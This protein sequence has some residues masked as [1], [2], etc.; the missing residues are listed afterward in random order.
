MRVEENTARTETFGRQ[1]EAKAFTINGSGF[2]FKTIMSGI[3]ADKE[4]SV[5]REIVANAVDAH[6]MYKEATG[7]SPTR[8][9]IVTLPSVFDSNFTVRD[10]G[11]GMPH[12]FVMDLYSRLFH[13]EKQN[14]N[15][16][17]GMFGLGSKSPF[18]L[19]D[20]FTVTVY[21]DGT[22]R[23]YP[24]ALGPDGIP[25]IR[26]MLPTISKEPS[27][28]KICVPIDNSRMAAFNAAYKRQLVAFF[29]ADI[30]LG[31]HKRSGLS[32]TLAHI[33]LS[34]HIRRIS[35]GLY[36]VPVN[37]IG[38]L[39]V[40][41]GTAVY[42]LTSDIAHRIQ[43]AL[44]P[45]ARRA[46]DFYRTQQSQYGLILDVPIGTCEVVPSRESL[47]SSEATLKSLVREALIIYSEASDQL[48]ARFIGCATIGEARERQARAS[49]VAVEPYD[50]RRHVDVPCVDP[51]GRLSA[52]AYRDARAYEPFYLPEVNKARAAQGL[53]PI[54]APIRH[55][56]RESDFVEIDATSS[57][58]LSAWA[59]MGA[60]SHRHTGVYGRTNSADLSDVERT[61]VLTPAAWMGHQIGL[62]GTTI[63]AARDIFDIVYLVPMRA[64]H[65]AERI[66]KHLNV[67]CPVYTDAALNVRAV[68]AAHLY[69]ATIYIMRVPAEILE[70]LRDYYKAGGCRFVYTLDETPELTDAEL[71]TLRGAS[72]GRKL[73]SKTAVY[74][75]N[76]DTS[77]EGLPVMFKGW[78]SDKVEV[79]ADKPAYYMRR[80]TKSS[81]VGFGTDTGRK[82]FAD[83]AFWPDGGETLQSRSS[84]HETELTNVLNRAL[85]VGWLEQGLPI[86]RLT[87][88]QAAAV[89]KEN[90]AADKALLAD[91][92]TDVCH[93]PWRELGDDILKN[94]ASELVSGSLTALFRDRASMPHVPDTVLSRIFNV[95]P[96]VPTDRWSEVNIIFLHTIAHAVSVND[97]VAANLYNKLWNAALGARLPSSSEFDACVGAQ[98]LPQR[99]RVWLVEQLFRHTNKAVAEDVNEVSFDADKQA[100]LLTEA[101]IEVCNRLSNMSASLFALRADIGTSGS[102]NKAHEILT[103]THYARYVR[104][105]LAE[106]LP[107]AYTLPA[108]PMTTAGIASLRKGMAAYLA[109]VVDGQKRYAPTA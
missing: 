26:A 16:A 79:V 27:G 83:A 20:Q 93:H 66:V 35:P 58:N 91:P 3:Y 60:K 41:Q 70:D 89:E 69:T 6:A 72:K 71:V 88:A 40:R 78:S 81:T 31:E 53:E 17:T 47:V 19:T 82:A 98:T 74:A 75:A 29:D 104:M 85:R 36:A 56:R 99:H 10:H 92:D 24:V 87:D 7:E 13:S 50:N 30:Q 108:T 45:H 52:V 14:T 68:Y 55:L 94:V 61:L 107:T 38:D 46:F 9:I 22:Q 11:A 59:C 103:A 4:G 12:E 28:T 109:A 96:R 37:L 105:L 1:L 77:P 39:S 48:T 44:T 65:W 32:P 63:P 100:H 18:A 33:S 102:D 51:S 15:V 42:P 5:V 97:F 64:R 34:A 54:V 21:R 23:V 86:Y 101:Q 8:S 49:S 84:L 95:L 76:I 62:S 25:V 2:A 80:M 67:S 43:Q 106:P 57:T 73:Y 90:E